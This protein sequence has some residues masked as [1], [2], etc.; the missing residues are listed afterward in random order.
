VWGND[1][2]GGHDLLIEN[3][4]GAFAAQRSPVFRKAGEFS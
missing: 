4:G 1:L 3:L 2:R